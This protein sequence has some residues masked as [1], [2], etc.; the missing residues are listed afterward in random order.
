MRLDGGPVAARD[1][2][3]ELELVLDGAPHER[4]ERLCRRAGQDERARRRLMQ[5]HEEVRG[6][7]GPRVVELAIG[8][9]E[10]EGAQAE[11][12]CKPVTARSRLDVPGGHRGKRAVELL[13]STRANERLERMDAEPAHVRVER[14]KRRR[15]AHVRHP[16]T[17]WNR[18]RHPGNRRIRHREHHEIRVGVGEESALG[19]A[20]GNRRPRPSPADDL[21]STEHRDR[22]SQY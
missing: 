16:W 9:G 15:A 7:G 22:V 5:R 2:P 21:D 18:S 17:G 11:H 19:E 13:G 4:H 14:G 3:G 6:H 1:R 8:L 10:I 20:R 12:A